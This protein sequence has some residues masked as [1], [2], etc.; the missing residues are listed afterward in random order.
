MSTEMTNWGIDPGFGGA[1]AWLIDGKL[2]IEA[3]PTVR[4]GPA[5]K[6]YDRPKMLALFRAIPK[7]LN[8]MLEAIQIHQHDARQSVSIN[9]IGFGH[10][11]MA[12]TAAG[13]PDSDIENVQPTSWQ[14][15]MHIGFFASFQN[16]KDRSFA[17]CHHLFPGVS[18]MR[19]SRATKPDD[20]FADA[21]LMALYAK[22]I[23]TGEA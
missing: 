14:G 9:G 18:L 15:L 11:Q 22:R 16:P 12:L 8:V 7:P 2:H 1:I 20:G 5:G 19:S 4:H 17:A 10:I 13:V 23:Q 6:R 21:A 3:L